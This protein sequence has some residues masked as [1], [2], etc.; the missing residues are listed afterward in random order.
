MTDNMIL[1]VYIA[2]PLAVGLGGWF[3]RSTMQ[4]ISDLEKSVALKVEEDKVRQLLVDKIEPLRED[5]QDLKVKLD[6]IID[7]LLKVDK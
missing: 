2:M 6:K 7:L 1:L 5:V 3:M 4:R